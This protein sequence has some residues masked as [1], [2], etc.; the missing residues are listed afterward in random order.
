MKFSSL[1]PLLLKASV[2][3]IIFHFKNKNVR[4]MN[5]SP[6]KESDRDE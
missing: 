3:S 4:R 1:M 2:F 6:E 5:S